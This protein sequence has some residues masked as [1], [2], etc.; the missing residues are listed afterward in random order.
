MVKLQFPN[1][2][3]IENLELNANTFISKEKVDESL[4]SD[5]ISELTVVKDDNNTSIMHNVVFVTQYQCGD[6]WYLA[7]R[8]MTKEELKK[9]E[10]MDSITELQLAIVEMYESEAN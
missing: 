7:L 8:E 10:L 4:F 3:V 2:T 5:I 1:G 9:K 6:E